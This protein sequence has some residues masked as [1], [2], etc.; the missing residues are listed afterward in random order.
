MKSILFTL[1][2]ICG[3]TSI[4][5]GTDFPPD[6][7]TTIFEKGTAKYF[8]SEGKRL[9]NEGDYRMSLVKFREALTKEDGNVEAIYWLAECHLALGNYEKALSYGEEALAKDPEVSSEV[10]NVVAICQHRLGLLELAIENYKKALGILNEGNAKILQVQFHIE[11]CERALEMIKN[12]IN[13]KISRMATTINTAFEETAPTLAPDGKTFYF[14]SRRADNKGGGISPAD[15][16]YYED[17]YVSIWD[18][19]KK[20]WGEATNSSELINRINT[21]GMDAI[22]HISGDGQTLYLTINTM[23]LQSPKP[24]T[25]HSDIFYCKMNRTGTWNSPKAMGSPINSFF[26]D[27]AISLTADES[28]CYFISERGGEKKQSDIY[29]SY[30]TGNSWSKPENLGDVINTEGNETTVFVS[31]DGVYL[32]FSSTG[33]EGMGG[34]D[35]FVSKNNGSEWSKP[36]NL[37]YP[38]NTVS[39]ETHFVYYPQLKRAYYSK[40]SSAENGGMGARDLFEIDMTNFVLP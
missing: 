21:N 7:T 32:Y 29:V 25:K 18:D 11:Q 20:E 30:K 8:I 2:L 31:P 17:V 22:S 10:N 14:V 19:A 16:R 15:Q 35:V 9:Y 1:L 40:F 6:S 36:V 28:T 3:Y 37:G 13:V 12:P 4:A 26:F 39:D 5:K 23:I 33:H 24:K 34:Y 38:I 27:A